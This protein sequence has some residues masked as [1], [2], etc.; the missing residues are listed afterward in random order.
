M[1]LHKSFLRCIM[2]VDWQIEAAQAYL[3]C[4]ISVV[5]EAVAPPKV[6]PF[7]SFHYLTNS[8]THGYSL[9]SGRMSMCMSDSGHLHLKTSF[10][11]SALRAHL[12]HKIQQRR[13]NKNWSEYK[14]VF[15]S[16]PE[17]R[18][19]PARYR[20]ASIGSFSGERSMLMNAVVASIPHIYLPRRC[21]CAGNNS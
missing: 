17:I 10:R 5:L 4:S 3:Q 21:T 12:S 20:M 6:R 2:L 14:P 8:K 11:P 18:L 19:V 9:K 13:R 7:S 15:D 16:H 1:W